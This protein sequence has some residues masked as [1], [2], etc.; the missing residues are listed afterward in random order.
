METSNVPIRLQVLKKQLSLPLS[1][2]FE[3]V[4]FLNKEPLSSQQQ[5]FVGK[6]LDSANELLSLINILQSLHFEHYDQI[7]HCESRKKKILLVEDDLLTQRVHREVLME[8]GYLVNI[9]QNAKEAIQTVEHG[10]DLVL[11]DI[12]LPDEDGITVCKTIRDRDK[13]TPIIAFSANGE[14]M[15]QCCLEAGMNDVLQKPAMCYQLK[16][17]IHKWVL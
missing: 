3:M 9:A 4:R 8:L 13:K 2:I 1:G 15:K 16:E 7:S 6:I 12:G 5:N 11:L 17:I 10:Y 14:A